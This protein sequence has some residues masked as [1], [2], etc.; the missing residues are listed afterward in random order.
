MIRYERI[1][2]L[3]FLRIF[4]TTP[5]RLSFKKNKIT[6][7]ATISIKKG[8]QRINGSIFLIQN[9]LFNN[10]ISISTAKKQ[11]CIETTLNFGKILLFVLRAINHRFQFLLRCNNHPR[12][13]TTIFTQIFY[14]GL[15]IQHK[16]GI[17]A[18]KLPNF[19]HQENNTCFILITILS[20]DFCKIFC[21]IGKI[22]SLI[23]Y[24]LAC[25]FIRH[26][27][28]GNQRFNYIISIQKSLR[29]GLLPTSI[30]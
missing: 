4:I 18:Y 3:K 19:V 17:I 24:K 9:S 23:F 27:T 14:T 5:S 26:S 28:N 7:L 8:F 1:Y 10:F 12:L 15:K 20:Y 22:T 29:S 2:I 30:G 25:A 16:L 11:T 6:Q 13:S 21:R